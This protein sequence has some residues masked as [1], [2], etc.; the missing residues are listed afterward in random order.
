MQ[1]GRNMQRAGIA[2]FFA[3]AAGLCLLC[4]CTAKDPLY[5]D[6]R[7]LCDKGYICNLETN[8]CETAPDSGPDG[9][10][11]VQARPDRPGRDVVV[12]NSKPDSKPDTAPDKGPDP[13]PDKGADISAPDSAPETAPD[14][15]SDLGPDISAPDSAPPPKCG[16][17]VIT[18]P[19]E[20]C[21]KTS[22]GGKTCKTQGFYGGTLKCQA[23]CKAFD[24]SACHDCGNGLV[25]PSEDCDTTQLAGKTCAKLSF[26]GGDLA[27]N[28]DCTYDK[29]A[30]Y[31]KWQV[32][33]GDH[34][35][36]MKKDGVLWCWGSNQAGALGDGTTKDKSIPVKVLGSM[37]W[38]SISVSGLHSCGVNKN[39]TLW[40]W[41]ENN[42]GQLGDGTKV[43]KNLPTPRTKTSRQKWATPRRGCPSRLAM[44]TAV[45]TTTEHCG[46]GAET[47]LASWATAPPR[48]KPSR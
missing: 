23:E 26:D 34:S 46:A 19:T 43:M 48:R 6:E 8:T 24:T 39:G 36:G 15:G 41:G 35:C 31:N 11:D 1:T 20:V 25:N 45:L 18:G 30:C 9:M 16:D 37:T 14:K 38:L 22:L 29:A 4:A 10:V 33:V 44:N 28:T 2:G 40:C 21:D 3:M 42:H 27:C 13:G 12:D 17:G 47:S 32:T 7:M 5:C